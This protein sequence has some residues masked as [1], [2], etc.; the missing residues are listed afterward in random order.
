MV[1]STTNHKQQTKN[2]IEP[3]E[4]IEPIKPIKPIKPLKPLNLLTPST[5]LPLPLSH[6]L[7]KPRSLW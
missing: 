3:I 6:F 1:A 4:L 7:L 5:L 2:K